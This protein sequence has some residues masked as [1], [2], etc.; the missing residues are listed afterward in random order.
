M[1]MKFQNVLHNATD[2]QSNIKNKFSYF[3]SL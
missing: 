3:S 1:L 2:A